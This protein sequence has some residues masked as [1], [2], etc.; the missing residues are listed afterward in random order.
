MLCYCLHCWPGIKL[1]GDTC[2]LIIKCKGCLKGA[3]CPF[4]YCTWPLSIVVIPF[5]QWM[6]HQPWN[7]HHWTDIDPHSGSLKSGLDPKKQ[8][9]ISLEKI[10]HKAGLDPEKQLGISLEKIKHNTSIHVPKDLGAAVWSRL[11]QNWMR[12]RMA[13]ISCRI[14]IIRRRKI[15]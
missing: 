8:L 12:N 13:K 14:I 1:L 7:V 6:R 10:K 4:T 11:L 3:E 5:K 9:G 2:I 15:C